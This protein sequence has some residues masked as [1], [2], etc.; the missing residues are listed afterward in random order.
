[1][2][3]ASEPKRSLKGETTPKRWLLLSAV[4]LVADQLTKLWFDATFRYGE[5]S[6]VLSFFDFTLLYNRGAAFSFLADEAGW[7]RWFFSVLGLG[8]SGFML[9]MMHN[10]RTQPR[11]LLALALILSGALGNVIDRL[12]YGH[13]IDF[14][15][16]YWQDW[17]YPAFNVADSCITLGAIL[18]I[19]DE[20]LRLRG[21]HARAS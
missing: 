13:V 15:L 20:I 18:L 2:T 14:L 21:R 11:L 9:W 12:L 7:Q 19:L 1:M 4:L 16:F 8:A 17:Y 6:Q 10:N 5:R 3:D